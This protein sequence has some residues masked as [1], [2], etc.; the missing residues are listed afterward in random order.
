MILR[1]LMH[2]IREQNW[3]A[4]GL[5]FLIVVLGVVIGF[6][7]T[8]WNDARTARLTETQ[9]LERLHDEIEG[10][11]AERWDWAAE[12]S[13][14]RGSL[15]SASPKL[16][17]TVEDDLSASECIAITQ[18]H[19]FNSASLGIPIVAELQSTGDLDLIRDGDVRQA[20]TNFLLTLTWSREMDAALNHETLNLSIRHPA[21]FEFIPPAAGEDWNPIFDGSARCD[22]AAMR[23]DRGFLNSLADNISKSRFF[24]TA[25]LDAPNASFRALHAA[26][27]LELGISHDEIK[28]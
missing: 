3:F 12:R 4:V 6:Q 15:L 14:T 2:A 20:I 24:M 18:S 10:L 27:D 28:S 19:V 7:V 23:L 5:E 25:V 26:V 1:R 11:E 17:G 13:R 16:F 22:T 21:L 9:L 8:A